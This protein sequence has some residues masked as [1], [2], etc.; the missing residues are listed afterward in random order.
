VPDRLRH[1]AW[2]ATFSLAAFGAAS[3]ATPADTLID[4]L[5]ISTA[6]VCLV[7][8][9]V[10]LTLGPYLQRRSGVR[11]INHYWR[12]DI[13]VW[14]ALAGIV[15]FVVATD[16]SM[17]PAYLE[18]YVLIDASGLSAPARDQFFTWGSIVGTLAGVLLLI[19]FCISNDW[20]LRRL[21]AARWRKVQW[22]AYPTFLLTAL[23]GLMFQLLESRALIWVGVLILVSA[24]VVGLRLQT[25]RQLSKGHSAGSMPD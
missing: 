13:G 6:W 8:I 2:L 1:H 15:H 18:A 22:L 11:P 25:H 24:A 20:S 5:S 12:R 9:A 17:N 16:V 19:L 7:L 23:H 21:G 4:H 10:A 3:W 14:A